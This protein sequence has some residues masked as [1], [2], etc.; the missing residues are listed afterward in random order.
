MKYFLAILH[1][2]LLVLIPLIMIPFLEYYKDTF[3]KPET[4]LSGL[5][6][7]TALITVGM[8]VITII[9]WVCAITNQSI[10]ELF[11]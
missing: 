9:R 3:C 4:D 2:I 1:T 7:L 6:M 8:M 10:G 5:Y 11:D